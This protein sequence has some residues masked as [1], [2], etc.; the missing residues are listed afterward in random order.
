MSVFNKLYIIILILYSCGTTKNEVVERK[1]EITKGNKYLSQL[2]LF[3]FLKNTKGIKEKFPYSVPF[4]TL[5]FDK[6]IAYDF[7]GREENMNVINYKTGRFTSVILRQK[8]LNVK[9]INYL[10]DFLTNNKTYGGNTAACFEPHL[11]IVFYKEDKKVFE[12]DICL[13]C[14]Y[15][16]STVEIPATKQMKQHKDG[17]SYELK[18]FSEM[19]KQNIIHLSKQLNLDYGK[20]N[21]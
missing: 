9:Q 21:D 2:E 19:G 4:D 12:V 3:N 5:K 11:G 6:V 10:I 1:E 16:I 20:W 15:L 7:D 18:G 17:T 8:E 13:D 14:N